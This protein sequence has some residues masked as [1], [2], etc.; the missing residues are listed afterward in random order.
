MD[1]ELIRQLRSEIRELDSLL[2][3]V[4]EE[5][6]IDRISLEGRRNQI[7]E[8]L[9]GYEN[10]RTDL[11]PTRL[12][13]RGAPVKGH[14][15]IWA[16]FGSEIVG[17]FNSAVE[18][19]GASS[20]QELGSRGSIPNAEDFRLMITG[21][22]RGSFGFQLHRASEQMVLVPDTD[23]VAVAVGR[24][25]EVMAATLLSDDELVATLADTD[26]RALGRV[27]GFLD[28]LAKHDATCAIESDQ[29]EFRFSDVDQVRRSAARL[30]A[31]NILERDV[32]LDGEFIGF[33]PESREAEFLVEGIRD[34]DADF[35]G[36][37][38]GSVIKGKVD[39]DVKDA[40]SINHFLEQSMSATV[41]TRRVGNSNPS[42]LFT[43]F[44]S[45]RII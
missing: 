35:L 26:S 18:A 20:T 44:G 28:T 27:K 39:Q 6:V 34:D 12:T 45:S 36:E 41:H 16:D 13:F 15:G 11:K 38:T 37:I 4:P 24:V 43:S 1:I 42:F 19:M 21:V 8:L 32:I 25:A 29:T 40:H 17:A 23:P 10:V 30:H 33:L 7:S 14:Q 22:A 9:E 31:E 5:H 3:D 2:A